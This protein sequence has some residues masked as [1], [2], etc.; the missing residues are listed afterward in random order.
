MF[1]LNGVIGLITPP[2]GTVL[3]VVAAV[4]RMRF[5]EVVV[6]VKPYLITYLLIMTL[7]VIF[8]QIVTAPIAWLR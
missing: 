7:F 8:P 6:G 1:I 5:E 2:V 4:G 3:N